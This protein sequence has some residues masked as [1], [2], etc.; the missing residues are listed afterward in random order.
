MFVITVILGALTQRAQY[1]VLPAVGVGLLAALLGH[2]P[3]IMYTLCS[4]A[5]PLLREY[6]ISCVFST[7]TVQCYIC[8]DIY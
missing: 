7:L 8:R 1:G 3:S 5:L 6:L 4:I 2:T